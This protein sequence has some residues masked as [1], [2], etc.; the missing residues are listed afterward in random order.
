M[1]AADVAWRYE[2]A[3]MRRQEARSSTRQAMVRK[4]PVVGDI[5]ALEQLCLLA[6][7]AMRPE[8][9]TSSQL[10]RIVEEFDRLRARLQ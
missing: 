4:R 6:G 2:E 7:A 9:L 3:T 10:E 8:Q 1:R 5:H